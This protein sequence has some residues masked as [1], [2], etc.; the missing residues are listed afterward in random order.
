MLR[1]NFG[2]KSLKSRQII[3][4]RVVTY[5]QR[6]IARYKLCKITKI[7]LNNLPVS[8]RMRLEPNVMLV[9]QKD[10][11]TRRLVSEDIDPKLR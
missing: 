4:I 2:L 5:L 1:K 11:A 10:R 9:A 3:S 7:I 6:Q 8:Y